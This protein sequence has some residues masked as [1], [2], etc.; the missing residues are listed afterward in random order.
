MGPL[1][2]LFGL[3][4]HGIKL[5]L[6]NIGA[7]CE[8]LGHPEQ[9][10]API[11]VAGTN[12]KGS[13][14]AMLDTALRSAGYTT[15]R[16]TSPHLSDL[17]ERFVIGGRPIA[18]DLLA[19]EAQRLHTTIQHLQA[20]RRLVSP[21]TFFEATTA[22]AF[23]LFR[24]AG[25]NVAVLEVGMGGRFDATNVVTPVAAVI[26]TIDRDHEHYLGSTLEA[27]AFEKA[28]V[29][30]SGALVV[31]GETKPGPAA[32][33]ARVCDEREARLIEA[34][35]GVEVDVTLEY[36]RSIVEI[37]TPVR[38]YGPARMR[39]RGRHQ[40][41]NAVTAIRL[42]EELRSIGLPVGASDILDALTQTRWPGRLEL[43]E[44]GERRSVLFDAAHNVAAATSL[45]DYLREVYPGGMPLIFAASRDKDS[46]GM[47]RAVAGA[48]T[49]VIC[50]QLATRRTCDPTEIVERAREACPALRVELA[51]SPSAALDAA[52]REANAVC[53]AGSIYLLSEL[54]DRIGAGGD[55]GVASQE[56]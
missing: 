34:G 40:V 25:A 55:G 8:A 35:D 36:G 30:K 17:R 15:G 53:A 43:I 56:S 20:S 37:A 9:S 46:V 19:W 50:P 14:A 21:P 3:E 31:S 48:V 45:A 29:I 13:V 10:F 23:S 42:L 5:G 4:R 2:Y 52:W 18:R 38:R 32:V 24:Q 41:A 39:L 26:T 1:D 6:D 51:D 47:L 49:R 12:G 11:L 54:T 22:I 16:Y 44:I 27:I 33:I 28:G 7:L